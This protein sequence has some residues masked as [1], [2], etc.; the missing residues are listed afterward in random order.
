MPIGNGRMGTLVWTDDAALHF[1]I[2]R[3]DV[4]AVN[5]EHQGVQFGAADYCGGCARVVLNL[6]DGALCVT[7]AFTQRLSLYDAEYTLTA[8]NLTVRCLVSSGTDMLQVEVDDRRR[9][10]QPVRVTLSLWRA[11]EVVNGGHCARAAMRAH[12]GA[13]S[14]VQQFSEGSHFCG[15]AVSLALPAGAKATAA[16]DANA[17]E[18]TFPSDGGKT[19]L[20]FSSAASWRR[21]EEAEICA[22]SILA[23]EAGQSY[24]ALREQHIPWWHAFWSRTYVHL[25]SEDGSAQQ[26]ERLRHLHLYYMASCSRGRLPPKFNGMLFNTQGDARTWGAQFWLWN[27]ELLYFSLFAADAWDLSEPYFNLYARMLPECEKAARQR[28]GLPGSYYPETMPFDGPALLP[29]D[30]AKEFQDVIYGRKPYTEFSPEAREWGGYCSQLRAL[31][32]ARDPKSPEWRLP[33]AGRYTW[34]SHIASS[35][36]EIALQAWWRYRYT[37]DEG[38]LRSAAYP[39]LRGVVEFYRHLAV[40]EADGRY[41]L[42]GINAHESFWGARDSTMD[43]AAIRGIAPIALRVSI[44]LGVDAELRPLWQDFLDALVPY[45]MGSDA[46]AKAL[47]GAV[48]ADDA[49]AAACLGDVQNNHNNEALC[50][51]PVF[52]FEDVTLVTPDQQVLRTAQRTLDLSPQRHVYLKGHT[53]CVHDRMPIIM[54]RMGRSEEMAACLLHHYTA[55]AGGVLAN[56]MSLAEGEQALS[57]EFLGTISAAVQD[58]LLQCLSPHPGEPEILHIIPALPRTWDAEFR[59]LARGGFLVSGQA[60]KGELKKLE[61]LSRRGETCRLRNPWTTPCRVSSPGDADC[62]LTGPICAFPTKP[63]ERYSLSPAT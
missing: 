57:A 58:S 30:I 24:A 17:Y 12:A 4:F 7:E 27:T 54:A 51:T 2:N 53:S 13:I 21:E 14:A 23:G 25:V 37:G 52:P 40:R 28:W 16:I 44:Q 6:G 15:S 32:E 10:P 46:G 34:I 41:H 26:I 31:S 9:D 56:A 50:M 29:D 3:S 5:R 1:Q 39:Q 55:G 62:V 11:A 43:L 33:A 35:G 19:V 8:E 49:W 63:G 38:W 60:G 59:L 61:I 48:L 18:V 36:A 20:R 45:P 42:S 22:L 47:N